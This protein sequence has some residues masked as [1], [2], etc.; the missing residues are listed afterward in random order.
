MYLQLTSK[1]QTMSPLNPYRPSGHYRPI[2]KKACTG[3]QTEK[4]IMFFIPGSPE[5]F[6][7][8]GV[9]SSSLS[10]DKTIVLG[11]SYASTVS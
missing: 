7:L 10:P 6:Y 11:L 2:R 1:P 3:K 8:T 9:Y 5:A 4:K